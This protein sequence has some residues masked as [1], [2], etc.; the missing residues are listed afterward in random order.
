MNPT[1]G[2]GNPENGFNRFAGSYDQ[3]ARIQ[4]IAAFE[5]AGI[6]KRYKHLIPRDNVLELGCGTG[7]LTEHLLDLFPESKIIASDLS[8]GML[9]I[10]KLKFSDHK[11]LQT[12]L[13]D[14]N[15]IPVSITEMGC[16]ASGFTLQWLTHPVGSI[17]QWMN[18]MHTDG[19]LFLS[20][21]GNGSF[22][23]W[24][25]MS[26]E[27]NVIYSGN[28]LPGR[29]I[30]DEIQRI[31][32]LDVLEYRVEN[33]EIVFDSSLSFFKS[34]RN[35]GAST[36]INPGVGYRNLL[37]L[38]REWDKRSPLGISVQHEL[39]YLVLKRSAIST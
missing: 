22:P 11:R 32:K 38:C 8:A 1:V 14:A 21:L 27:V 33:K 2:K 17:Q 24:K 12:A 6:I 29:E 37:H 10:Q 31:S 13:I 26:S 18:A 20:W 25:A 34:I 15:Q 39:H 30:V 23:E 5:L 36:E 19:L 35:I 7:L 16:I 9:D 4:A 3:F 28:V